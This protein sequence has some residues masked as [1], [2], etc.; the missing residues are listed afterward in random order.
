MWRLDLR[1]APYECLESV[2]PKSTPTVHLLQR[3]A[4]NRRKHVE[5]AGIVILILLVCTSSGSARA[6]TMQ[7]TRLR[8]ADGMAMVYVPAGSF[9]MG[10]TD[11]QLALILSMDEDI[12][13]SDYNDEQPAHEVSVGGFWIDQTEVTNAQF[14]EF[15][16][17]CGNQVEGGVR[18]WE[19]GAGHRGIVYGLIEEIDGRYRPRQGYGNYPVI[20]VSWY[21]AR[22]YCEWI[23]GRLPTEAEWEYAARGTLST[24]FPWGNEFRDEAACCAETSVR[25]VPDMPGWSA[26]GSYPEGASWCGALDMAGNVWEWVADWWDPAYYSVSAATNPAGPDSGTVR[27][28]RG[29]SWYDEAWRLCCGDRKGSSS[30]SERMHW[31]GFRCV[32]PDE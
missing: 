8:A 30:S 4:M 17:E 32:I 24:L 3:R 25:R 5:V 21:G 1:C 13:Q 9:L 12:V 22:A 27:I 15:L 6:G 23:G 10:Y 28:A 7:E 14:C 19:P 11:E 29:G 2:A 31:V 20:E 18:R 26:V 16:N